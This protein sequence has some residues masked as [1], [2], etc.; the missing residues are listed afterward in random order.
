M[1]DHDHERRGR[2]LAR[3]LL[4]HLPRLRDRHLQDRATALLRDQGGHSPVL[5]IVNTSLAVRRDLAY[6][7]RLEPRRHW[8]RL[9]YRPMPHAA[10]DRALSLL[11]P[12]RGRVSN[13]GSFLRSVDRTAVK[14]G[15]VEVMVY[16]DEDDPA[17]PSYRRLFARAPGLWTGLGACRLVVGPAEG[18]PRAWNA[19]AARAKGDLLMM[20]NDDQ[21]YVDHGWDTELDNRVTQLTTLHG[22]DVLCLYFDDGQYSDG[23]R[24]FP[25]VT[26][27]WYDTLGYFTPTA[28]QQW[29]VERWVFDIA[30]RLDRCHA[31]PGVFVEHRHYQDYK[32]PFDETYQRHRATREKSFAD[33]ALFLR[34]EPQR[35]AEGERLRR[36]MAPGPQPGSG[37][38]PPDSARTERPVT[39]LPE[40]WFASRLVASRARI[41]AEATA[42]RDRV[43][44]GGE[45]LTASLWADGLPAADRAADF[46]ATLDVL[47]AI[48]EI[49]AAPDGTAALEWWPVGSDAPAVVRQGSTTLFPLSGT[50]GLRLRLGGH[51]DHPWPADGCV[52]YVASPAQ[53]M[54]NDGPDGALVLVL[55]TAPSVA[56]SRSGG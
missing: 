41:T 32:A 54:R 23:G 53:E 39:M 50:H 17:L 15:R 26:R 55:V 14:P 38:P 33:H 19:L 12:S 30:L 42:W 40:P 29:E 51:D 28:F 56:D 45:P 35:V 36:V 16:V 7:L 46:P 48:P 37:F 1:S 52:R 5:G 31:V 22:D 24:D 34:T 43:A 4:G 9:T 18:V 27:S 25:I 8:S 21:L 20:A 3:L 13:L 47:A 11:C 49:A 2:T 10:P 6:W 44:P